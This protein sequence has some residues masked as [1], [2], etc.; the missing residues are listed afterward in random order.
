GKAISEAVMNSIDAC[1]TRVDIKLNAGSM[2]ITDDGQ[3]FLDKT[4]I[5]AWFETMGF[6]H[7]EGNHRQF[8]FYGMGRAQMWAYASTVWHTNQFKMSV[9][10]AKTA[11][12]YKLEEVLEPHRGTKIVATFYSP[13]SL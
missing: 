2:T 11:L 13:L 1:A 3:G 6:P 7:D 4:E 9:D 8:G 5:A 12:A 10:V